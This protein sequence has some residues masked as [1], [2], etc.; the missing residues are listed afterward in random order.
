MGQRIRIYI[1]EVRIEMLRLADMR[2][3]AETVLGDM[4]DI[5]PICMI[6][7]NRNFWWSPVVS[8]I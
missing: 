4:S 3:N 1:M 7:L 8:S 2:K 5:C 6:N